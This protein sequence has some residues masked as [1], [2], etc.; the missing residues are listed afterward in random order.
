MCSAFAM[1]GVPTTLLVPA[2][3]STLRALRSLPTTLWD[4]YGVSPNFSIT[5]LPFPYPRAVFQ[6]SLHA[7]VVAAYARLKRLELVYTRSEWV[8]IL[9]ARLGIATVLE[10]HHLSRGPAQARAARAARELNPL[11]GVVCVSEALREEMIR[12]GFPA[13]KLLVAPDGVDLARF[14]APLTTAEARRLLGLPEEGRIVCHLGHLYPGRGVE[15]LLQCAAR[16]PDIGFLLV[17]GDTADISLHRQAVERQR[18]S[19]VRF[20]GMVPNT[21]VPRYLYAA[22]VVV[23]PYTQGTPTHRFMSPMKMFEY[24]ASSRPIV[25]SDHPVL[26]EIL[27]PDEN[28]I[29]VPPGDVDAFVAG[30]TRVLADQALASRLASRARDDVRAYSWQRRAERI[31]TFVNGAAA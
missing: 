14:A 11:I 19:N 25:A 4:Y 3:L 22:N 2:R 6:R 29:F 30:L 18:L 9:L 20:V 5:W 10:L 8:A 16:L 17:G 21:I 27:S 26:H 1:T 13:E 24:M 7:L 31:L 28:A 23:M 15:V 12:Q